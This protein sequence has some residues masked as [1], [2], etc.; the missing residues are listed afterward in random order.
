MVRRAAASVLLLAL[1][2][3]P[4]P[5][6]G[7]E[8]CSKVVVITMPSVTWADVQREAPPNILAVVEHGAVG[9]VSVRTDSPVTSY[10]DG[11]LTIGAGARAEAGDVTP[12]EDLDDLPETRPAIQAF[13][14]DTKVAVFSELEELAKRAAYEPR[15]GALATALGTIETAAMGSS[16]L[17]ERPSPPGRGRW[18]LFTAM[19]EDGVVA[20]SLAE[21]TLIVDSEAPFRVRTDTS[22][23][24]HA[25]NFGL[26][27][28]YVAIV[29][30][31]DLI[32][33]EQAL[34]RGDA[35]VPMREPLLALDEIVAGMR[36]QLD[37]E[38]D[39][40]L[41][42]SP[43]SPLT[44]PLA[45]LGV[46]VAEGPGFS[47]G[48]SLTSATTGAEGIVTLSDVAPTILEH[49]GK[50]RPTEMVGRG[51]T[52]VAG[53]GDR[54]GAAVD[55]D[56]EARFA[57]RNQPLVSGIFAVAELFLVLGAVWLSRRKSSVRAIRS[58]ALGFLAFPFVAFA[59]TP[60]PAERM[61]FPLYLGALVAL[62]ALVVVVVSL[63]RREPYERAILI[64]L[65]T[66]VLLG[67]DLAM[68]ARLQ[69]T[70]IWGNDAILGGRFDGLG[71]I[72]FSVLGANAIVAAALLV[73]RG[74]G[75][76]IPLLVAI[77]L[78][79]AVVIDGA[80]GVGSDVGGVLAMVPT[81]IL[82]WF[83]L[84]GRRIGAEAVV[85]ALLIGAVVLGI[86]AA[87]D[88]SRPEAQQTH[89]ARLIDDVSARG[90]GPFT[91][92]VERKTRANVGVFGESP[93]SFLIPPIFVG[94]FWLVIGRRGR[95]GALA[96]K[97][98]AIRAGLLGGFCLAVL[99]FAANDSGVVVM[100][101]VMAVLAP[102]AVLALTRPDEV[103]A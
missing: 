36:K 48:N 93:A 74:R 22:R 34:L 41:L 90:V 102:A 23:I 62:T 53:D 86:F 51:W 85:A 50:P 29:D 77:V 2:A 13:N 100:A 44:D 84:T 88:L 96:D 92:A 82:T 38:R 55:L 97:Q 10:G 56:D 80:P 66:V 59:S 49:L 27:D 6:H 20:K 25:P 73:Q 87:I 103:T 71:N 4:A 67:I 26:D 11:F 98:P 37:P 64:C 17:G 65:A 83:L 21:N 12:V 69:L 39:L 9:S 40:L 47:P 45:H 79:L 101:V 28:C 42:V 52:S 8:T 81:M 78:G 58:L 70:G 89:L 75:D 35:S 32:R 19:D 5:A 91:D 15:I 7:A 72:G 94:F 30:G 46:A 31:G 18:A 61:G 16:D 1:A 99:G 54:L 43:T 14:E 60:L 3:F 57:H 33:R 68:G 24:V 63:V 76:R 95:W